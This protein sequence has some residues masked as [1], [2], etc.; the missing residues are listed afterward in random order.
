MHL[1][2]GS[3][4]NSIKVWAA[5]SF[6]QKLHAG[7]PLLT[8]NSS[9][10]EEN[11]P[12]PHSFGNPNYKWTIKLAVNTMAQDSFC[13]PHITLPLLPDSSPNYLKCIPSAWV[14]EGAQFDWKNLLPK[15]SV[16]S[17]T[18]TVIFAQQSPYT[19]LGCWVEEDSPSFIVVSSW[20]PQTSTHSYKHF[21]F[22]EP[23]PH[24]AGAALVDGL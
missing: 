1:W 24:P 11:I 10:P 4:N 23:S 7:F 2:K 9:R 18:V 15:S 19:S 21:T 13:L 20:H 22:C 14:S 12:R 8:T 5:L 17:S 16:E 6:N 3:Q